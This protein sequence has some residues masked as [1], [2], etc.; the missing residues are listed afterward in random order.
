LIGVDCGWTVI[1][2]TGNT[3]GRF[4]LGRGVKYD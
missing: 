4:Y 3:F 1:T 2:V